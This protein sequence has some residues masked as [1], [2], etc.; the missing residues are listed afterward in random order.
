MLRHQL[1]LTNEA[2]LGVNKI[3]IL[4]GSRSGPLCVLKANPVVVAGRQTTASLAQ[5]NRKTLSIRQPPGC[6]AATAALAA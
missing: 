6:A 1:F 3:L 2:R 5:V 4:C